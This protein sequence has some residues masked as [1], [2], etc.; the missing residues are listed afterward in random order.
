[1]RSHIVFVDIPRTNIHFPLE[2]LT[3][4]ARKFG[5]DLEYQRE[6]LTEE[7]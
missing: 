5:V 3:V 4:N 1:M 7:T 6:D 2:R